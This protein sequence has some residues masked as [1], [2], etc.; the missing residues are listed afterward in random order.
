MLLRKYNLDHVTDNAGRAIPRKCLRNLPA[1]P[2]GCGM[3]RDIEVNSVTSMVAQYNEDKQQAKAH[4]R[5][6]QEIN[7]HYCWTWLSRK[8]R[9]VCEGGFR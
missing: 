6:D 5:H 7:R 9:Q 2:F 4:C 1:R 3:R 8:V